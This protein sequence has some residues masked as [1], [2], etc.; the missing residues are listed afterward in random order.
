MRIFVFIEINSYSKVLSVENYKIS[1]DQQGR[2][3]KENE[4]A[5]HEPTEAEKEEERKKQEEKKEE[6]FLF[7]FINF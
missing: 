4:P 5:K 7:S 3:N 6:G 1:D 2:E